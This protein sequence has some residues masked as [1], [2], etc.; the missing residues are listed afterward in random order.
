[1]GP[2]TGHLFLHGRGQALFEQLHRL[3]AAG[4][5]DTSC[6]FSL[7]HFSRQ[8]VRVPCVFLFHGLRNESVSEQ[9]VS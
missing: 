6:L 8:D 9:E 2:A 1:M 4:C 7:A 3:L 5:G